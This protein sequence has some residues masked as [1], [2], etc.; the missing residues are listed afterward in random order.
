[1]TEEQEML[2]RTWWM[3]LITETFTKWHNIDFGI[4]LCKHSDTRGVEMETNCS[5]PLEWTERCWMCSFW[6][7]LVIIHYVNSYIAAMQELL[8]FTRTKLFLGSTNENAK[9]TK[10]QICMWAL[11][12]FFFWM[13]FLPNDL[14]RWYHKYQ[15]RESFFFRPP[16]WCMLTFQ[17][18]HTWSVHVNVI[19]SSAHSK[20]ICEIETVACFD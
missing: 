17:N 2:K 5:W 8:K 20:T 11:S 13:F 7:N 12:I 9:L 1:M 16:P 4:Q 3:G 15:I 6:P 19:A 14:W 10:T 18:S